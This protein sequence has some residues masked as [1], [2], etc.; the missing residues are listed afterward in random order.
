MAPVLAETRC[1]IAA[2]YEAKDFGVKTGTGLREARQLCPE[3]VV[4][5]ARPSEYVRLHHEVVGAVES[6]IHVEEVLSI[7]E[8]WAWLPYNWREP[9]FVETLGRRIKMTVAHRCSPVI[10]VSIGA[11]PNRYLAKIASKLDKP[12][13]LR[14]LRHSDLPEALYGLEL[15]D[16]T[17]ISRS[18]ELRLHA[19]GIHTVEELCAAPKEVLR[20]VWRGLLGE[21]MWLQLRGEEV[22]DPPTTRK[23]LGHSHVLPPA[24]RTPE[25]AW[26]VLCKLTHKACERLRSLGLMCGE[27]VVQVGFRDGERYGPELRVAQTHSTLEILNWVRHLWKAIPRRRAEIVQV[28]MVLQRLTQAAGHT[29]DLFSNPVKEEKLRRLD[30]ALDSLRV[31]YG[32]DVVHLGIVHEAR[33]SAPM[34]ISFGHVPEVGLEGDRLES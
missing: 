25:K 11:A 1:C 30:Q 23:S 7:D 34:R 27:I 31:R 9:E 10:K 33:D 12:D 2:S 6:C 8:M 3:L 22:P 19:A 32:R 24:L 26:P 21:R 29:P 15:T 4:V 18:M 17:G 5:E 28:G 16:L 14:I 20:G 13:G